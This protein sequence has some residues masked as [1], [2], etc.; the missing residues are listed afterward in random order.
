[1]GLMLYGIFVV[2]GVRPIPVALGLSIVVLAVAVESL[3][4]VLPGRPPR[5]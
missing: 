5:A 2:P 1:M 4:E 3:S